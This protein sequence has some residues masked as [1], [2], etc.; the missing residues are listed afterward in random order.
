MDQFSQLARDD[1]EVCQGFREEGIGAISH[2]TFTIVANKPHEPEVF[3]GT[4]PSTNL[5]NFFRNSPQSSNG[6]YNEKIRPSLQIVTIGTSYTSTFES[7]LDVK[8]DAFME[9]IDSMGANHGAL[10]LVTH[11]YDGFHRLSSPH[12]SGTETYFLGTSLCAILWTFSPSTQRTMA[13]FMQRFKSYR[14]GLEMDFEHL[15]D[16][17]EQHSQYVYSS[18]LV[19]YVSTLSLA[20]FW[21]A[22]LEDN[23]LSSVWNIERFTGYGPGSSG[24]G[25]MYDIHEL[26]SS[27]QRIG[28]ALNNMTNKQRHLRIMESVLDWIVQYEPEG[29]VEIR[30]ETLESLQKL[31]ECVPFMKSRIQASQEYLGYLKERSERL[32]SV[33]RSRSHQLEMISTSNSRMP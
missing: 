9:L 29:P 3:R 31:V 21:D 1:L 6:Y 11:R 15:T 24:P 33:V 12:M 27:L 5:A 28:G 8:K 7:I 32:Y 26:T 2:S 10:W 4:F 25:V 17:L 19:P 16:M 18:M 14:G 13:I 22:N 23:Q 30:A 20:W